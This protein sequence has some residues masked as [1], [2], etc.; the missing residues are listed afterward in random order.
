[1]VKEKWYNITCGVHMG[2]T[3][4][5]FQCYCMLET[6]HNNMLP[7]IITNPP[8]RKLYPK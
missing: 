3:V 5:F 7:K 4:K 8:L 6:F 1:M 2:F